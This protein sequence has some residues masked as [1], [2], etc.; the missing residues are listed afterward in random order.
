MPGLAVIIGKGSRYPTQE[1][2]T[3]L[4]S[5]QGK[6]TTNT[7]KF[8]LD[9]MN[10]YAGWTGQ[11]DPSFDRGPAS[12]QSPE[13]NILFNGEHY[14]PTT[15][16]HGS[17]S[18]SC[19]SS[20]E[21]AL[22]LLDLYERS[23][24][25]FP[26]TLNGFFHGL[27]ID[28]RADK[29]ILFIDRFGMRRLYYHEE[30][31]VIYLSTEAKAILSVRPAL[32]SFDPLGLG[33]WLSCGAVLEDRTLFSGV[34]ALPAGSIWIWRPDGS[35]SRRAYFSP[36]AWEDRERLDPESFFERL[37]QSFPGILARYLNPNGRTGLSTTGGLDTRLILAHLGA[38]RKDVHC[39]SF[40]G[41]YR[42]SLDVAIGRKAARIAGCPHTTL[43]IDAG[44]FDRF[45]DLAKDVVL[46]T[47]GNLDLT[48]APNL[49]MCEL[50]REISPVRLTGNYGS[51]VLRQTRTFGM[52]TSI[53]AF[54]SPAYM[55]FVEKASAPWSRIVTDKILTFIV[56]RQIPWYSYNRL[57]LEESA[58][59]MRSPFMDNDLL[60]IMY[61]APAGLK[62][63]NDL[64]LRLISDGD[65]RLG[66]LPTDRGLTYPRRPWGPLLRAYF[67]FI[68]R[69]E[70]FASHGMPRQLAGLD[71]NLGPLSLER[72]FIGRNK[73]YHLRQWFRD[74]LSGFVRDLAL[75]PRTLH[76][77]YLN[78]TAVRNAVEKHLAG[79]E[80]HTQAINKIMTLE[81]TNQLILQSAH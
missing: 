44:F 32:R 27:I 81:L 42:E 9:R 6:K 7:H 41:P 43:R 47:D 30:P 45:E 20:H 37:L 64:C 23:G 26:L 59:I 33:E 68:F 40:C 35:Q 16:N 39:Y 71:R 75:D 51:E 4:T 46:R 54:L 21:G 36:S 65:P 11:D 18:K 10:I 72:L 1:L 14:S 48:G 13:V 67:E 80:N 74:E 2:D 5:L 53:S 34:K 28:S 66:A 52:N 60:E 73:Y 78:G 77:D 12:A 62:A 38:H 25:D 58:T 19:E 55:E 17:L 69:M 29:A 79:V 56:F 49:Y 61:Q 22:R 15:Q 63:W 24:E 50:S 57:Q 8:I 70:Y 31:D 3:M 76:R